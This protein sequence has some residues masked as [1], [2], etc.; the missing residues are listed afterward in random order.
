MSN[1]QSNTEN[2]F[3]NAHTHIFH[4][5]DTPA[6]LA[7]KIVVWPFY[8]F[9]NTHWFVSLA[10]KLRA[11]KSKEYSYRSRNKAWQ[12]YLTSRY[13][14]YG[15]IKRC[16]LFIA[17]IVFFFYLVYILQPM[18]A[19]WPLEGWL[20]QFYESEA[21]DQFLFLD[22]R[23]EY[24]VILLPLFLLF[25]N[26]RRSLFKLLVTYIKTKFGKENIEFYIRYK[27]LL[28]FARYEKSANIFSKLKSQYPPGSKFV[29]LPMDMEFM[30]AGAIKRSYRDQMKE[31]L[32]LKNNNKEIIYPFL[33][34]HPK[35]LKEEINGYPY[36]AGAL[37]QDGN[38][39]LQEC[40]V[41]YY[42]EKGCAGVKIYPAMGYYPFDEALLPLWLYC[43]QNG[44]PITTHCSVG[45]IFYRGNLKD[46]RQPIDQ[47]PVF[48]QIIEKDENDN[49]IIKDL[50]LPLHKNSVFQRNFTHPLNYLCLLD[51]NFL[52]DVLDYY[53]NVDLD[54]L[55]GYDRKDKA[56][57]LDRNLSNLKINL[58]HYGGAENWE[59]FLS[60]DRYNE[61][62]YIINRPTEGLRLH[63]RLNNDKP[64]ILYNAWHFIDWF[65]II[66]SMILNYENVYTDISYTTHDLKYL[67][68]LSE[69]LDN[70][71]ISKRVLY[72]TDFYV[73]SN[74][75]TEKQY[76]IDMQN[77]LGYKKWNKIANINP[78]EF[79]TSNS[80][81]SI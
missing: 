17:N 54:D 15:F 10:Q 12:K 34:A 67:N 65:S 76:W 53:N 80:K 7:K 44:I 62:N 68:L 33:F 38:Y 30:K 19:F 3:I 81:G 71:K 58:A 45:P 20:K 42:F 29:T 1:K 4:A 50:R 57:K 28:S 8:Y 25:V 11:N 74:H 26:L 36:F 70:E 22:R 77:S 69:I 40:D 39:Q 52:K 48:N 31:L 14:L 35:R 24:L 59:E 51:E 41:K 27:N 56:K 66:S 49:E 16:V 63:K 21:I 37:D 18:M 61:A 72:G 79:L 32:T 60:K 13:S 23:F 5:K 43:S 55:F 46:L 73:V 75:K 2:S 6:H 47:H 64:T 78:T 9:I